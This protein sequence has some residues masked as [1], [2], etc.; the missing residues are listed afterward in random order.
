M[1]T[2]LFSFF[3]PAKRIL[4]TII[5]DIDTKGENTFDLYT[6]LSSKKIDSDN[7]KRSTKIEA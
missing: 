4:N 7:W 5:D 6:I 3:F 2:S 1:V